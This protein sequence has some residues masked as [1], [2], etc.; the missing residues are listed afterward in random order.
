MFFFLSPSKS[1]LN[2]RGRLL[3]FSPSFVVLVNFTCV[4]LYVC[5]IKEGREEKTRRRR[6]LTTT[7]RH[8]AIG[9][10]LVF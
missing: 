7:T 2:A 3:L 10:D 6:R 4:V 9:R 1:S 8:V 5:V